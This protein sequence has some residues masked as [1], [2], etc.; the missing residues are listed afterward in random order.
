M[1]EGAEGI[2]NLDE[3]AAVAGVDAIFL[4]PVDISASM[5]RPNQPEHPDVVDALADLFARCAANGTVCG[6]Y[7]PNA[8]AAARWF[9]RGAVFVAASADVAMILGA[10]ERLAVEI[11]AARGR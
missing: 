9:N 8:A 7:A 11:G 4:G 3:I 5:G 1:V 6:V 10:F 2:R